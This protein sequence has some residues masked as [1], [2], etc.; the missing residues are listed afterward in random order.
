MEAP[1]SSAKAMDATA[2]ARLVAA[3]LG[4]PEADSRPLGEGWDSVAVLIGGRFVVR[5]PKSVSAR[6]GLAREVA[7][8]R[9]ARDSLPVPTPRILAAVRETEA[10]PFGF[11][12]HEYIEGVSLSEA[13][14]PVVSPAADDPLSGRLARFIEAMHGFRPADPSL[15]PSESYR[16]AFEEYRSD[17]ERS[18]M[19]I[20]RPAQAERL[21]SLFDRY[22]DDD[23]NFAFT[24][25]LLHADLSSEHILIHARSRELAGIID[26]GDVG[27]GDPIYELGFLYADFGSRWVAAMSARLGWSQEAAVA[28]AR[29][30]AITNQVD[31]IVHGPGP[32][33]AGQV[34]LAWATLRTLLAT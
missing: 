20:L 19:P 31:T 32:A 27:W 7:F 22:L 10:F 34:Q 25:V 12:V 2:A 13:T 11:A 9:E 1:L 4:L 23:D 15:F 30:Y 17:A 6:D 8:L 28:R 16:A 5:F 3:E 24:P 18:V 29:F 33:L 21:R 26:F 14:E